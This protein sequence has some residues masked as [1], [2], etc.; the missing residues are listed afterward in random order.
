MPPQEILILAVTQ[1]TGGVCIAGM[2]TEPD[3]STGLRWVRPVRDHDHVLLGD[4]TTA[5]GAVIQPFDVVELHLL[6]AQPSPPH[7]E[8]WIADF[9]RH[10]P[11]IL[12]RLEGERRTAF[13]RKYVD[14]DPA[15]VLKSLA[16]S[17]CLVRP[18]WVNGRFDLDTHTGKLEARLAFGLDQDRYLGSVEKG[19]ISVTDLRWR[20]LGR[21][22]LPPAGGVLEFDSDALRARLGLHDLFLAIGL[23]R[24]FQGARWPIVIGVHVVPDYDAVVDYSNL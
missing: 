8:D 21:A 22:M 24:T 18:G 15:S 23:T 4:I 19:G 12:R 20:A 2:S 10:R 1:M 14:P 5:D 13:L 6:R 7:T 16:R 11:R 3:P 17:L 9:A